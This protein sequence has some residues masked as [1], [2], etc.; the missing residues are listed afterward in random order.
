MASDYVTPSGSSDVTGS[1]FGP[2]DDNYF[3][4]TQGSPELRGDLKVSVNDDILEEFS[5]ICNTAREGPGKDLYE[6]MMWH[7][8]GDGLCLGRVGTDQW[9][10]NERD[11]CEY[12]SHKRCRVALA[13]GWYL[14]NC[15]RKQ[16]CFRFP[17]LP[18]DVADNSDAFNMH[19]SER[20]ESSAVDCYHC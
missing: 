11:A 12:D 1:F 5:P 7:G 18:L 6:L 19:R 10:N 9:C 14:I 15:K 20:Y 4:P 13:P 3:S 8:E 16:A 2:A 17:H